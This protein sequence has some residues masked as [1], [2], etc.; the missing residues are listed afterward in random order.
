MDLRFKHP[1]T[2]IVAGP[3]GCGKTTFITN[4]LQGG[5]KICNVEFTHIIWC[6]SLHHPPLDALGKKITYIRGVPDIASKV[7]HA[8]TLIVL[9]DLMSKK[10]KS[11]IV[12]LFTQG[13]HHLNV[14]VVYIS[15]N[16]FHK[17]KEERDISLNAHYIVMF[18][19][20]RDNSQIRH[21]AYQVYPQNPAFLSKCYYMVTRH[22]H[23]YLLIDFKQC[24]PEIC[25][26]RTN[27]FSENEPFF[28]LA[29]AENINGDTELNN[30]FS[31]GYTME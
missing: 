30:A 1:F 22:A 23:G 14:S 4:I 13:S 5:D 17:A 9:D 16:I 12:H 31:Y 8:P 29:Y 24:T 18:K 25:R 2:A 15:Q 6:Y 27:I 7:F 28:P 21:L 26:I 20:P 10:D 19:N 3:S 11:A